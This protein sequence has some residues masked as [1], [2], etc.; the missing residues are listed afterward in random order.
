VLWVATDGA[1][2]GSCG[3]ADDECQSIDH[4]LSLATAGDAVCVREGT[5]DESWVEVPSGVRLISADG[6]QAAAIYSGTE[7]AVRFTDGVDGASIE[8]FEV[9]GDWDQGDPGDGLIR[10]HDATNITVYRVVAH[11]APYDQDVVK[12][13]GQVSGLVLDGIVAYNPAHRT[14]GMF[15]ENIDIFGSGATG[16][17]PPPVSGVVVR[18]CWLFHTANGGDFLLYSKIY[19]ERILY[20]NNIFGPSAG[21][22]WGN[23]AVGVGTGEVGIPDPTAPVIVDAIVRNNIF[24]GLVGDGALGVFNS[25][26]V[27]IY[28]NTFFDNSGADL[29]SVIMLRGN[30]YQ[31]GPTYVRNNVFV[32]NNPAMSGAAFYWVR[33]SGQPS[34]W[35]HQNNVYDNNIAATDTPY[36]GE[37][38]SL[39]D[40]DPLLAAPAVPDTSSPSLARI[41]EIK[42]HFALGAGSPALDAGIDAVG[43]SGHPN[44]EPG[45]TD[46]RWDYQGQARATGGPWDMGVDEQ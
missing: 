32:D 6:D 16:S 28:N 31:V 26:N 35:V 37:D 43:Q 1:D 8:G 20:E 13:S 9:Y 22:G 45:A 10:I 39:Y 30:S 19:V 17:D 40:T 46:R 14:N 5:Y 38:G 33:D 12:V 4:A 2:S 18:N 42:A 25:D 11:D 44:W 7:S 3:A 34:T 24:V 15:Q 21:D 23:V 29:R 36:S 41:D 27:W